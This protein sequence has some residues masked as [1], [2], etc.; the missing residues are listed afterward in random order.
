MP[1]ITKT[2][3]SDILIER[4]LF[5]VLRGRRFCLYQPTLGKIQLVSRLWEQIAPTGEHKQV[6]YLAQML[7]AGKAKRDVCLRLLAYSTLP[8]AECLDENAVLRRI[9]QLRGINT[10]DLVSLVITAVSMDKSG[11]ILGYYEID[12]ELERL[13]KVS[14]L[15]DKD[16]GSATFAGKSIWG[17]L[18]DA[19]CERYGWSYQYVLWGISYTNL[20][21]LLADQ[22]KTV[23]L[24]DEERKRA[25]SLLADKGD[26]VKA[27]DKNALRSFVK[28]QSWR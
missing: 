19:A 2:E 4:P 24:S 9:K 22:V 20:Q 3:I 28:S 6:H 15:K 21:L 11:E 7:E 13:R 26:I 10:P 25:G 8:G 23:F 12:R 14:A 1:S 17:T 18:I 5:F 27:D 16:K